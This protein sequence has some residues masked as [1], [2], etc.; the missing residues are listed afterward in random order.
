M[1]VLIKKVFKTFERFVFGV[2][3]WLQEDKW[4]ILS[5][6]AQSTAS[7]QDIQS[8]MLLFYSAF[9]IPSFNGYRNNSKHTKQ[10]SEDMWPVAK[11][12]RLRVERYIAVVVKRT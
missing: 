9:F 7:K 2:F 11:G 12:L 4:K 6:D 3:L 8:Q 1:F 5:A 10:L